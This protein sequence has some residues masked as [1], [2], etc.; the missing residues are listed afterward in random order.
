M[1]CAILLANQTR[2]RVF[3]DTTLAELAR[4]T[5]VVIRPVEKIT[6][7]NAA[8]IIAGAG[9]AITSWGSV[10]LE[11]PILDAAPDLKIVAHAA[12][13]VKGI[14][15]DELVR[16]G[17]RITSAAAALGVGVAEYTLGAMLMMG[18]RLKEQMRSVE[19]GG[20]GSPAAARML[21]M[22]RASVGIVGAG[23]VGR[24]LVRLLKNFE[25]ESIS[26]YDPYLASDKASELGVRKASLEDLFAGSDYICICAP[27]TAETRGMISRKL[28]Q[29]IRDDA[30]FVN[31]AR[32]AIVDEAALADELKTGRFLA[33]ID[34]TEPEPPRPD[35]PLR[36][37][38]NVIMTPHMAGAVTRNVKRNGLFAA[39]EIINFVDGKPLNFPVD[40]SSLDKIA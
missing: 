1:K 12:G 10:R 25:L 5:E 21:E 8:E 15:S 27:S 4:K 31:A 16:R 33:L 7:E 35:H 24:N 37:L 39:R 23:F 11:K 36:N 17:I 22:F 29:S 19:S 9:A 38:P 3:D 28:I 2:A 6:P 30:V 26:V 18:K 40:L 20:W 14:V 34:V 13:S 32:G